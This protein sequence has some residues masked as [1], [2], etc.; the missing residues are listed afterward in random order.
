MG[1]TNS[2]GGSLGRVLGDDEEGEEGS[3]GIKDFHLCLV[4][5]PIYIH[6]VGVYVYVW[7]TWMYE[8]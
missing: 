5:P 4:F 8:W 6:T 7:N 3:L 2:F 1:Q